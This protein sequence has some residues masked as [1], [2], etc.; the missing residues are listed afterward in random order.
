MSRLKAKYNAEVKAK[1]QEKF[2][3]KNVMQIP[4]MTKIVIAMGVAEAVKDKNVIQDCVKELT[5]I[6]GQKPIIT[7]SKKA[8]SNFKLRED[9]PIGVKVT[10]RGKRMYDFIDR[11]C[12]IVAPR[13]KDFRGFNTKGDGRG[14]YTFGLSDQQMFPELNLD[15]VKRDQGMHITFVTT[16]KNDGECIELLTQLGFPFK[17]GD[18]N[19]A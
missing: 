13:I 1:L 14:C 6:S 15:E 3:Y 4:K 10:M 9:Y 18:A 2:N 11:F 7:R 5:L 16:A 8:I 19:V 17:R 12:N